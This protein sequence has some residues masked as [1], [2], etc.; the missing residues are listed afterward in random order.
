M[1]QII[2]LKLLDFLK[3]EKKINKLMMVLAY[4]YK[5][6]CVNKN[7]WLNFRYKQRAYTFNIWLIRFKKQQQL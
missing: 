2:H 7:K 4:Q 3:V 1:S 5:I 6:P